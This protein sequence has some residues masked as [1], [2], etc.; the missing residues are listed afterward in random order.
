MAI[1]VAKPAQCTTSQK[2][3]KG[4]WAIEKMSA[5]KCHELSY[6]LSQVGETDPVDTALAST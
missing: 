4:S 2:N 1:C 6:T 3:Q 5:V